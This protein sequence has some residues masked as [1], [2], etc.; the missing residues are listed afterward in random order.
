[1]T[2]PYSVE[3]KEKKFGARDQGFIATSPAMAKFRTAGTQLDP[4]VRTLFGHVHLY[5]VGTP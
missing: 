5:L 1:M 3:K 4:A 2:A